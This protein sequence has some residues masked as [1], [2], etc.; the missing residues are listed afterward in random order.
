MLNKFYP[1]TTRLVDAATNREHIIP[2]AL[3]GPNG[4][5]LR[6]DDKT[7]SRYGSTVDLQ[8]IHDPL[9]QLMASKAGVVSRS[10]PVD[11]EQRG[12]LEDGSAV[13]VTMGPSGA[14]FRMR[15]PVTKDAETGKISG[16][17]GFGPEA[18]EHLQRVTEEFARKGVTIEPN[19]VKTLGGEVR[20]SICHRI[21][22]TTQGLAKIAYLA[23]VWSLGDAFICSSGAAQ[24]RKLLDGDATE[25]AFAASGVTVLTMTTQPFETPEPADTY[26]VIACMQRNGGIATMVRL[27]GAGLL[28]RTFLVD[29]PDL[30]ANCLPNPRVFLVNAAAHSMRILD[31]TDG[32][33]GLQG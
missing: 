30:P 18:Q 27:F 9:I 22:P 21:L 7:N 6:A 31:E 17:R 13:L 16:V 29:T 26:H 20:V 1:Y 28:S 8:L 11:W 33:Y 3:G 5:A 19:E 24:Y 4:F 15:V 32:S 25:D 14:D 10:G 2:D 12:Q 23:T